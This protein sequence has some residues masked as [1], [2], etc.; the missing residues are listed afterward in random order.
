MIEQV[1]AHLSPEFKN[2]EMDKLA[3]KR[4]SVCFGWLHLGLGN[5]NGNAES[6]GAGAD[7]KSVDEK[8]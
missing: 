1:Y 2:S 7:E 3:P 6:K 8:S 4:R 5:G